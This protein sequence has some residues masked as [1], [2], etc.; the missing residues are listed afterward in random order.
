MASESWPFV[1]E[2]T[3]PSSLFS[4]DEFTPTE[5]STTKDKAAFGNHFFL[6]RGRVEAISID[7]RRLKH[8]AALTHHFCYRWEVVGS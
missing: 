6:H 4:A 3:M 8:P 7:Q 5:F 2:P 1:L